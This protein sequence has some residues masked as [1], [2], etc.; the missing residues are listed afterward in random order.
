MVYATPGITL[1]MRCFS[2]MDM[3]WNWVRAEIPEK[4]VLFYIYLPL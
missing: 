2:G 3:E 1:P 4:K